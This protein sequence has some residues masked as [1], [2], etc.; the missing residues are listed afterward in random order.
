MSR[1]I[2]PNETHG[3][4]GRT[5]TAPT[6]TTATAATA[7]TVSEGPYCELPYYPPPLVHD[8]RVSHS[9]ADRVSS[10]YG[11]PCLGRY[12]HHDQHH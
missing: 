10:E 4:A 8:D 3:R 9:R 6:D 7:A 2:G 12:H 1:T 5:T 11:H